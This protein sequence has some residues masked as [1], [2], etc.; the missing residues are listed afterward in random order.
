MNGLLDNMSKNWMPWVDHK[1]KFPLAN[2]DKVVKPRGDTRNG[3]R[4]QHS[5]GTI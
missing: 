2:F 3:I 4:P 1:R 5:L